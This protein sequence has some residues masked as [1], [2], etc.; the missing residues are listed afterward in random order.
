METHKLLAMG[1]VGYLANVVDKS[2]HKDTK[3]EDVHIAIEFKE[4]FPED[5]LG[6]PQDC[7]IELVPITGLIS[8]APY[9]MAPIELKEL[10]KQYRSCWKKVS[11]IPAI[12]HGVL[13]CYWL[14]KRMDQ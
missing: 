3:I 8:K 6:L 9:H 2:K 4:V 13:Q 11:S 10:H 12:L 5:L 1:C 7:E 14:R